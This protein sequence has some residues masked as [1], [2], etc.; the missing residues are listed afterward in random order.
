MV[1]RKSF[2]LDK[3]QM[4]TRHS[5][6]KSS[7]VR[8]NMTPIVIS[9]MIIFVI[10]LTIIFLFDAYLPNREY[11]FT[12]DLLYERIAN[13]I[14][15][16]VLVLCIYFFPS[17]FVIVRYTAL[18]LLTSYCAAQLAVCQNVFKKSYK[19]RPNPY[20]VNLMITLATCVATSAMVC[21]V[22]Y[23]FQATDFVRSY[24]LNC[25]KNCNDAI[26]PITR[27]GT[28]MVVISTYSLLFQF[29]IIHHHNFE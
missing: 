23:R 27:I 19:R 12:S 1:H 14:I 25:P 8:V 16:I 3:Q 26:Y 11:V 4:K 28:L 6:I 24:L 15:V 29:L 9:I 21:W 2:F 20:F 18:F 7:P 17:S 10:T 22:I 13:V 5:T